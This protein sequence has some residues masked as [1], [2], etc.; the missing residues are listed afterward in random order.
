MNL[1]YIRRSQSQRQ[2]SQHKII[3]IIL[4]LSFKILIWKTHLQMIINSI[5]KHISIIIN[6][7]NNILQ[8][9]RPLK[10]YNLFFTHKLQSRIP[11]H[12][13]L[14]N[15]QPLIKFNF[16]LLLFQILLI[17]NRRQLQQRI[18]HLNQQRLIKILIKKVLLFF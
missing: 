3:F 5:Y 10:Q 18:H 1:L 12:L 13:K 8:K 15:I 11:I 14:L 4:Q 17:V 9:M 16:Q 6:L 7:N 2:I